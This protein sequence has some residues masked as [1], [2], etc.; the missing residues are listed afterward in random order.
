MF[1]DKFDYI[2]RVRSTDDS[3]LWLR[4]EGLVCRASY[5][6]PPVIIWTQAL[7]DFK[8]KSECKK[9]TYLFKFGFLYQQRI[10]KV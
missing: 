6:Q 8:N 10:F 9:Y 4:I 1:I 2:I 5:H 3:S 7:K